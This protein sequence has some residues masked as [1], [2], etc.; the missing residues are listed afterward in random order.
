MKVGH[1]MNGE[2]TESSSCT[3]QFSSMFS[4]VQLFATPWTAAHQ[5]S[6]SVT[7]TWSPH[8]PISTEPMIASNNLILCHPLL[9]LSSSFPASGTFQKSLLFA[10]GVK[11]TGVSASISVLPMNI[12]DWSPLGWTVGYPCSPRDSQEPSPTL[13]FKS[14]NSLVPS[15]L[16]SPSLTSIHDYWKNSSLEQTDL[17][18]QSDV[19]TC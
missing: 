19:S 14:I 1:Y 11:S 10:S 15:F 9:L 18:W 2:S 4:R 12:Q 16:Y 3:A 6:L 7:N 13:Q 5:A 17:C 8:K